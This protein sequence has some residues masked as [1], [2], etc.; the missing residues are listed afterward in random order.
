MKTRWMLW[1]LMLAA[2]SMSAAPCGSLTANVPRAFASVGPSQLHT[3][4]FDADGHPDVLAIGQGQVVLHYG[5]AEGTLEPGITLATGVQRALV[6]DINADGAPDVVIQASAVPGVYVRFNLNHRL[7]DISRQLTA[8]EGDLVAAG[9]F[10]RD[11]FIDLVLGG[12]LFPLTALVNDGRVQFDRAETTP[13]AIRAERAGSGDFDGDGD[14]D[15]VAL[16][17]SADNLNIVRNDG[18]GHFTL[19][20]IENGLATPL[21]A[22]FDRDGRADVVTM[23]ESMRTVA[24]YEARTAPLSRELISTGDRA[25]SGV[26]ADFNNDG[27]IDLAVQQAG[28]ETQP[29]RIVVYLN[30]GRGELVQRFD[31][32]AGVDP[33]V[34]RLAAA[35]M[36]GDGALDLIVPSEFPPLGIAVVLGRGD[37]TFRVPVR[38]PGPEGSA[39][40]LAADMNGDGIDEL[41]TTAFGR[42]YVGTLNAA[43]GYTFE[44]LAGGPQGTTFVAVGELHAAAGNELAVGRANQVTIYGRSNT[45][46]LTAFGGFIAPDQITGMTVAQLDAGAG[47]EIA[48]TTLD[49]RLRVV[50]T[51]IRVPSIIAIRPTDAANLFAFDA[52]RDGDNDLLLIARGTSVW[53]PHASMPNADGYVSLFRNRGNG[54]FDP[55][56]RILSDRMSVFGVVGDFNGDGRRD[57]LVASEEGRLLLA[58]DGQGHFIPTPTVAP[59][60]NVVDINQDGIDD[61]VAGS[62]I[63]TIYYGTTNG[64]EAGESLMF[65][66]SNEVIA[67]RRSRTGPPALVTTLRDSGTLQVMEAVCETG[68]RRSARH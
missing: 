30:D 23:N 42:V 65:G 57:A 62:R 26:A 36:N 39:A 47:D 17:V 59:P 1:T 54:T 25:R 55:E 66:D 8:R 14:L 11:G 40:E 20:P 24:L 64:L 29:W 38:Y 49:H 56:E 48:F 45:G 52:D 32:P 13:F 12:A 4:D 15:L 67:V 60:G 53:S 7:F 37:G 18:S 46:S 63:I 3:A 43:R 68:R 61:V 35:D 16:G 28:G 21:V 19:T 33:R 9:D 6:A 58:G 41:I 34:E 2:V 27:F 22:D 10:T 31:F 44:E 50:T 51:D 5:T